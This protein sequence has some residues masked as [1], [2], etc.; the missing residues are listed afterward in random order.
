[1][2][3]AAR[4]DALGW[5]WPHS[6][7]PRGLSSRPYKEPASPSLVAPQGSNFPSAPGSPGI[8]ARAAASSEQEAPLAPLST[9]AA[10][11]QLAFPPGIQRVQLTIAKH[12]AVLG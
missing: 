4:G 7:A 2:S 12:L 6:P 3:G 8:A 10:C 5:R 9:P 11:S 1:M